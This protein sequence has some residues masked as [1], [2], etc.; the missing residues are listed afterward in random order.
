[1]YGHG[2]KPNDDLFGFFAPDVQSSIITDKNGDPSVAF[3]IKA[4]LALT[5]YF[6]P[7]FGMGVYCDYNYA[8]KKVS[9]EFDYLTLDITR[10]YHVINPGIQAM[11]RF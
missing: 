10:H 5:Y 8:Y 3:A 9:F 6:S 2:E 7:A 1:M 4:S 11:I